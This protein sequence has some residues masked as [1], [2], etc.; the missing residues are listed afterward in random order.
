MES[1]TLDQWHS[2]QVT[3]IRIENDPGEEVNLFQK[4]RCP[5]SVPMQ[6]SDPA[7]DKQTHSD[8][9]DGVCSIIGVRS[10]PMTISEN[11]PREIP[12]MSRVWSLQACL[13]IFISVMTFSAY[14]YYLR[15]GPS[16]LSSC[17]TDT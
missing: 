14:L 16:V 17:S 7:Q 13:D 4:P 2:Q 9:R 12:V 1:T 11:T 3:L 8:L 5:D 15:H 6:M 10:T